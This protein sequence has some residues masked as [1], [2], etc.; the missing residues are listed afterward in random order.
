MM[1]K[2]NL[3]IGVG[4]VTIR[5]SLVLGHTVYAQSLRHHQ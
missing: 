3:Y 4:V 1:I 5:Q 2:D